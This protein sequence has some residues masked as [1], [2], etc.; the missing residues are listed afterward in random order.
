MTSAKASSSGVV[1]LDNNATTPLYSGCVTAANKWIMPAN[2]SA[3]TKYGQLA[4]KMIAETK[5][6]LAKHMNCKKTH[7]IMFTSGASESNC[8]I[9]RAL[10]D[11][12]NDRKA[13]R[14]PCIVVSNIEHKSVLECLYALRKQLGGIVVVKA[15]PTTSRV[16]PDTLRAT[17]ADQKNV[18]LVMIMHGNNE[19][20]ALN[21]IAS[22]AK[23]VHKHGAIFHVDC[24]QTF[25]KY[26]I[27]MD[28][29]GIDSLAMSFHKLYGPRGL[30]LWVLRTKLREKGFG[31]IISGSQQF[32]LRGGTENVPAIAG[33]MPCM[34]YVFAER[35]A[36]NAKLKA[37]RDYAIE[38]LAK[39]F[40][41][42]W[43]AAES[44]AAS[45]GTEC[46]FMMLTPKQGSL[47]NTMLIS[48]VKPLG[49]AFC[50]V[51]LKKALNAAGVIVSIGSACLTK[52]D[53]ASHVVE[54]FGVTPEVRRGVIRVT[55]GDFNTKKDVAYFAKCFVAAVTAQL[56]DIIVAE[57]K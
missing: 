36:K 15:D 17:L 51:K 39:A 28:A 8:T 2:P 11:F 41:V 44:S 26:R 6:Y 31:G 43:W 54:A 47:P 32:G 10:I 23:I 24:V 40:L 16:E 18:D 38:L 12:F 14:K 50:N 49:A 53:K 56:S 5:D 48:F 9:V 55:F 30:G 7:D 21:D 27:D 52:S 29:M 37:L 19:S 22:L 13:K 57:K 33:V 46:C 35:R 42:K 20:G 34:K 4:D 3:S 45:P 1:Y 25:G